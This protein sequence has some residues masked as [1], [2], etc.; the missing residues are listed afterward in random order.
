MATLFETGLAISA[1]SAGASVIGQQQQYSANKANAEQSFRIQ[2]QQTNLGI[3]QQEASDGLKAQQSQ[4]DMLKAA[5][6]AKASAG[7]SGTAG[8]SVDSLIGDYQAAEG[9]YLNSLTTQQQ[10][11][12]A[13]AAVQ[14][15][16]QAATAQA[17]INSVAPPDFLGAAL[18]IAGDGLNQ[19]T[20]LYVRPSTGR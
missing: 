14:K 8:N 2:N 17:R 16:G 4:T 1:A 11:D 20:N 12:R 7:E 13:Q 15:Q 6:T 5:A 3:Q 9:R 18:R 10:W 19:Y